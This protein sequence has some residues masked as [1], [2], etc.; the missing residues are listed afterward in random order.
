MGTHS[1]RD[2]DSLVTARARSQVVRS[3]R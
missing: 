3:V 2:I 1:Q